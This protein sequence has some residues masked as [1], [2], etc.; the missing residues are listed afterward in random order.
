M[1]TKIMAGFICF[2]MLCFCGQIY[3]GMANGRANVVLG[4]LDFDHNCAN[5]VDGNEVVYP[6]AIYADDAGDRLFVADTS[7]HRVLWWDDIS[8][9]YN[10]KSA[11]GVLGQAD[12]LHGKSNRGSA[13]A[14]EN[15]FS[16]PCGVCV[17]ISGNVWVADYSNH[18]VLRFSGTLTNGMNADIVL[19][20]ADFVSRL[21][22]RGGGVSANTINIPRA[23]ASDSSG[24]IWVG[25]LGNGRVLRY[26]PPFSNGMDADLVIGQTNFTDSTSGTDANKV[27]GTSGISFDPSGNLYICELDQSRAMRFSVPLSSG[28][29]ADL[30]L[31]QENFTSK[32]P[33]RGGSVGINTLSRPRGLGVDSSG[34]VWVSDSLNSRIVRYSVPLSSGMDADLVLGQGDFNTDSINRGTGVGADTMYNVF[35]GVYIDLSGNVW[36]ADSHNN[37]VL[38]YSVPVSSGMNANLVL[39]QNDFTHNGFNVVEKNT[40]RYPSSIAVDSVNNR[41][42]VADYSN[43]RILWWNKLTDFYNGNDADGVLGQSGFLSDM[44]NR[45]GAVGA[46]TLSAPYD[47]A[48]DSAGNVWVSDSGNNRIV[49]YNGALTNGMDAGLVLGQADLI[50]NLSNRGTGVDVN[51]LA[52]PQGICFDSGG[53]MWVA[54]TDN[55]RVL[56]YNAAFTNGMDAV[57]VLGQDVFTLRKANRNLQV[58]ANSLS[59]P[60]DVGID[61]SGNIW[62]TD[63]SNNRALRYGGDITSGMDAGIVLGQDVFV[64]SQPNRGLTVA[65]NTLFS[66]GGINFDG[67][68]NIWIS[69]SDNN[70]VIRYGGI[71]STGQNA[72]AV[73]GQDSFISGSVNLDNL[74]SGVKGLHDP[75]GICFDAAGGLWVTDSLNQR[76]L[77]FNPLKITSVSASSGAR[78][79]VAN[80]VISGEGI[81]SGP[82]VK[83]AR[84]G[85][86][87]ILA[88][89]ISVAGETQLSCGFDLADAATGYWNVVL[90][91]GVFSP[92][93]AESFFVY[94]PTASST[95]LDVSKDNEVR[96]RGEFIDVKLDIPAGAF[97]ENIDLSVSLPPYSCE[98]HQKGL[99]AADIWIEISNDKNL[100]PLKDITATVTYSDSY[101]S[102]VEESMLAMFRYDDAGA[103]WFWVPSTP[104]PGENKVVATIKHLSLFG[105]FQSSVRQNLNDVFVYPTPYRPGSGTKYDN[106]SSGEGVV[107]GGL[108]PRARINI[109]TIAGELVDSIEEIDGDGLLLWN[110]RNM[111]GSKAA[112]GVYIYRVTNT[113]D[114]SQKARGKLVIIR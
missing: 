67:E 15:S 28:M 58:A 72:D 62:V 6:Y 12:F 92:V 86:A 46:N 100:K 55:N 21:V 91:S 47:V 78:D 2:G 30:V 13:V 41:I 87:D 69:D 98:L 96:L 101:V 95:A 106:T 5:I 83:L 26:S 31:G 107:F 44:A 65:E 27:S 64:S 8:S 29:S 16:G 112:S 88:S 80:V 102:N 89:N 36:V 74:T 81:P 50:S 3:A 32:S 14:A 33:N 52:A 23:I 68:G 42:F 37:R 75:N 35:G 59:S 34:N 11:D 18:R 105:I 10:G 25:D 84:Q 76:V 48:V 49:R 94:I 82:C 97:S 45:G 19:G 22:N 43:N 53:N 51:T 60:Y 4:Q 17:D 66:P 79:A 57:V 73:I 24:N 61:T 54:D 103:T 85:Q 111:G 9:F 20:Q 39:G 70:R 40:L 109:Y 114:N 7:N 108:T 110:T 99:K 71:I 63:Y 93:M 104:Y 1:K 56:R 113:D 38:K 77:M 90:T